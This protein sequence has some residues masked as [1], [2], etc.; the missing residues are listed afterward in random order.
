MT[1]KKEHLHSLHME[2]LGVDVVWFAK[3]SMGRRVVGAIGPKR[4]LAHRQQS[5]VWLATSTGEPLLSGY[6]PGPHGSLEQL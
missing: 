2:I 6:S 4:E 1:M 3:R 5:R